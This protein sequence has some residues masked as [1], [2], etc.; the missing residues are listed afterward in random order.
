MNAANQFTVVSAFHI[1]PEPVALMSDDDIAYRFS[2]SLSHLP[3]EG[4]NGN[5]YGLAGDSDE[6]TQISVD[7][8]D[9]FQTAAGDEFAPEGGN[10]DTNQALDNPIFVTN[11]DPTRNPTVSVVN[12]NLAPATVGGPN[13]GPAR[14]P[15]SNDPSVDAVVGG[16]ATEVNGDIVLTVSGAYDGSGL[17]VDQHVI[18]G[19]SGDTIVTG[20]GNDFF[21][22]GA[23]NDILAGNGG[24]DVIDG[25]AGNDV[26]VGGSGEGND[27]FSGGEGDDTVIYRSA[28][29][30]ITVNLTDGTASGVD[31]GIDSLS[32]IENVVGGAGNDTIVG[33]DGDN[34]LTGGA[35]NDSLDGRGGND[36]AVMSGNRSDYTI[37][38]LADGDF[39]I[40]DGRA[41]GDGTDLVRGVEF[42]RFADG[43]VSA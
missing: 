4:N 15:S 23:G 1:G 42:F 21:A 17:N 13:S 16:P 6:L 35:G 11:G 10:S 18:G 36:T 39:Q 5:D 31:I 27:E 25:G 38:R 20:E 3:T 43:T 14:I 7:G 41:A 12:L 2:T 9:E 29:D 30:G 22:G 32:G 8:L 34:Q 33:N 37:V 40:T 26:I 19:G 28:V 24:N